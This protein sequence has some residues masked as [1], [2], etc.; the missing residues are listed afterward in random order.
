MKTPILNFTHP[1]ALT[2]AVATGLLLH[3]PPRVHA[4]IIVTHWNFNSTPPDA[5]TTTGSLAP[6]SGSGTA[7]GFGGVTVSFSDASGSTSPV[8][9]DNS[10]LGLATFP[11]QGTGSG[12]RGAEFRVPTVGYEQISVRWDQRFSSTA[13]RNYEFQYSLDGTTF[14]PF[15]Q[16]RNTAGGNAWMNGNLVDLGSVAG[17]SDNPNFAFRVVS[18]FEPGTSAYAASA[19]GSSYSGSGTWR[20][21]E[22]MVQGTPTTA[23]IPEP[24]EY[25][26]LAVGTLAGFAWWRRQQRL[27]PNQTDRPGQ[28]A[29]TVAAARQ[30]PDWDRAQAAG[31]FD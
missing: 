5:R 4:Q 29:A 9:T 1:A 3:L 14:T 25:A 31:D 30:R 13:S 17:V 28:V 11:G 20:F 2:L 7:A 19:P 26:L 21:D 12:S 16:L 27:R 6:A 24:P 15:A 22:M 23:V 18:V 8:T 10:G